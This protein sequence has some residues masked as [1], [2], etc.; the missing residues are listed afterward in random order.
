MPSISRFGLG[1]TTSA[2]FAQILRQQRTRKCGSKWLHCQRHHKWIGT[3]ADAQILAHAKKLRPLGVVDLPAAVLAAPDRIEIPALPTLG[4]QPGPAGG[5]HAN[6]CRAR[7][8]S[9]R[10]SVTTALTLIFSLR[11]IRHRPASALASCLPNAPDSRAKSSLIESRNAAGSRCS[12][13]CAIAATLDR[14]S[15]S[16]SER[17]HA[18]SA[19]AMQASQMQRRRSASIGS[20]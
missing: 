6:L 10:T 16:G 8:P 4:Q 1:A 3:I 7:S 5:K 11:R 2:G 19:K 14:S 15:R 12:I 18:P 13:A 20:A 9:I 17:L